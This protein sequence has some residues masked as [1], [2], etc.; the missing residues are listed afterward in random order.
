MRPAAMLALAVLLAACGA[1]P[2]ADELLRDQGSGPA[3]APVFVDAGHPPIELGRASD[4]SLPSRYGIGREAST[5]EIAL[6]DID[7][8]PDGAGLPPGRGTP[9]QG[10]AL[11]AARCAAC[12]GVDGT[13]ASAGAL[14]A[15]GDPHEWVDGTARNAFSTRTVGNYWPYAP[16]LFDY[17][18]R[19]MP[20]DQPGSLTDDEVYAV[21]AWLLWKNDLV[22]EDAVMDAVTLPA[23]VMPARDRFVPDDRLTSPRVR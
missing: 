11:Y 9:A 13:G 18:R 23:V 2:S 1:A 20:F 22:G 19:A 7:V 14:V 16:T 3:D 21:V 15:E 17:V 12:H 5:E 10:A 8:M 6:L 4:E